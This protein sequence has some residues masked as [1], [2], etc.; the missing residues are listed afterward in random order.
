MAVT[1]IVTDGVVA[2]E[3]DFQFVKSKLKSD[4]PVCSI[5]RCIHPFEEGELNRFY[6]NRRFQKK[7][8]CLAPV[9]FRN[10]AS[11]CI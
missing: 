6:N 11:K 1:I 8:G 4:Y 7:L 2:F 3:L 9:E 5:K 10:Q